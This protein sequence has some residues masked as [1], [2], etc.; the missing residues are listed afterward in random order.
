MDKNQLK[1]N[2][3]LTFSE[4]AVITEKDKQEIIDNTL[5]ALRNQVNRGLGLAPIDGDYITDIIEVKDEKGSGILWDM[6]EDTQI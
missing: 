3:T 1:L 2:I 5:S 6:K 4:D